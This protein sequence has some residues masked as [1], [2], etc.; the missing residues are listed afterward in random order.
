MT[1][2]FGNKFISFQDFSQLYWDNKTNCKSNL[3]LELMLQKS[4]F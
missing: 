1:R 3:N 4:L 2:D